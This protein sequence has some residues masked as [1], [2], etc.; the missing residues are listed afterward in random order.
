QQR[1]ER[2]ERT[3]Q[4]EG[5]R[6]TGGFDGSA[7]FGRRRFHYQDSTTTVVDWQG[8]QPG[9]PRCQSTPRPSA[10]QRGRNLPDAAALGAAPGAPPISAWIGGTGA[11]EVKTASGRLAATRMSDS[12]SF[13]WPSGCTRGGASMIWPERCQPCQ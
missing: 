10:A 3:E 5:A 6:P 2:A 1:G 11:G 8:R 4:A 7:R 12:S 13:F 9:S